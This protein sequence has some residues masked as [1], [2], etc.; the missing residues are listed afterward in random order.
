M[1]LILAKTSI[2][3]LGRDGFNFCLLENPF[4]NVVFALF[5][6]TL[7]HTDFHFSFDILAQIMK[8]SAFLCGDCVIGHLAMEIMTAFEKVNWRFFGKFC[9]K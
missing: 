4:S 1:A 5:L 6:L 7:K 8:F 2:Y 3:R 9:H